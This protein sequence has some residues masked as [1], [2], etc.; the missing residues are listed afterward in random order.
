MRTI[1]AVAVAWVIAWPG[2]TGAIVGARSP[3]QVDGWI[4]ATKLHLT[5]ADLQE[6]AHAIERTRAGIGANHATAT[7][8]AGRLTDQIERHGRGKMRA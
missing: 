8:C 1:A 4:D 7:T 6:V 2:V 5:F 3:Q